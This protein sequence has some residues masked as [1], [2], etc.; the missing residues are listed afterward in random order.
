MRELVFNPEQIAVLKRTRNLVLLKDRFG[1]ALGHAIFAR[2]EPPDEAFIDWNTL[3][4]D[5]QAIF[6]GR[7]AAKARLDGES[8]A[9]E[10]R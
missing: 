6:E 4:D 1:N 5:V 9:G 2:P 7:R 3:R 8:S 10:P